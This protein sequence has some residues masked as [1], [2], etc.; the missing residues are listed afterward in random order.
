MHDV[1][2]LMIKKDGE[3]YKANAY[4]DHNKREIHIAVLSKYGKLTDTEY[5]SRLLSL[6]RHELSHPIIIELWGIEGGDNKNSHELMAKL[7]LGA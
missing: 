1:E 5:K 3:D 2:F 6:I 7:N 4:S